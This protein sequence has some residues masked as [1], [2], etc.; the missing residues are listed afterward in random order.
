MSLKDQVIAEAYKWIGYQE[1]SNGGE[2]TFSP[3]GGFG[4]DAQWCG[5]FVEHC[6]RSQGAAPG[7]SVI[8][9]LYYTPSAAADFISRGAWKF[10][11]EVGDC[12]LFDWGGAGLGS[13]T[14]LID[15]I[16]LVTNVDNWLSQGYVTTVEGNI[17]G[18]AGVPA[19][20][21][22]RRYSS[23]ISGFGK[24]AWGT[25]A[26]PPFVAK[27]GAW[28]K[29]PV[30]LSWVQPG[31]RNGAIAQVQ[32][33]ILANGVPNI[34]PLLRFT[35]DARYVQAYQIIQKR[36]G[37]TGADA[38]GHPGLESLKKL[39]FAVV[40]EANPATVVPAPPPNKVLPGVRRVHVQPGNSNGQVLTVRRALY[41]TGIKVG[42][43]NPA[44]G[45]AFVKA[46]AQWQ[47]MCGLTGAAANGVPDNATLLK[48][49]GKTKMFILV[50]P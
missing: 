14:G 27:T 18:S 33:A 24:P 29:T 2:Y 16:G 21:E 30:K 20:G 13:N 36:M 10:T 22:F 37:Y 48:L 31:Q 38:D 8:P 28:T 23:V 43:A 35:G 6:F 46:Y 15:H 25:P 11:P 17:T 50:R 44:A 1:N 5:L 49:A 26:P 19:V 12:I 39:G 45:P 9:R 41:K 47:R 40:K 32:D 4:P 42:I 3:E 34:W 7:G